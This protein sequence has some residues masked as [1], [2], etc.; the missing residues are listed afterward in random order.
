MAST[1]VTS[2]GSSYKATTE[3]PGN[4]SNNSSGSSNGI[5]HS[6]YSSS[7]SSSPS[8]VMST[9]TRI[10]QQQQQQQ[11]QQQDHQYQL[12]GG[13]DG[14]IETDDN[15][16]GKYRRQKRM[17]STLTYLVFAV[18]LLGFTIW[19]VG[20]RS[21]T[22]TNS[23][24]GIGDDSKMNHDLH[25]QR[26]RD[27]DARRRK[28]QKWKTEKEEERDD[29]V[30]SH[31]VVNKRW[32]NKLK[33]QEFPRGGSD[34]DDHESSSEE[35]DNNSKEGKVNAVYSWF[36]RGGG[37]GEEEEAEKLRVDALEEDLTELDKRMNSN[38]DQHIKWIDM[39]DVPPLH[40]NS[41]EGRKRR[42]LV[43]G[44]EGK[45][46]RGIHPGHNKQGSFKKF[47]QIHRPNKEK[48]VWE[49]E[50]DTIVNKDPT[51]RSTYVDYTK[52]QYRYPKKL[53][54]P[55]DRLGEY[56]KLRTYGELYKTWPQDA[57][58]DPPDIIQEDLIHFDYND[59][60]DMKA[61][62]KFRT[63][64]L[65]FKLINVPEL[66]AAN[67]KWTDEYISQQ[68]DTKKANGRANETPNNFFAF[69]NEPIWDVTKQGVPP[70]RNNDWTYKKWSKHARYADRVGLDANLPHFY[71]QSGVPAEERRQPDDTWSF[72]SKDLPSWSSSESNF[73][74]FQVE[75]QKG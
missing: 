52:H 56:P 69:F 41:K 28:N 38:K 12:R 39:S 53:F 37:E 47:F 46:V 23:E 1:I 4:Y 64:R 9:M 11:Q 16:Y 59:P 3:P 57:I 31:R 50:F 48:M 61:A 36:Q 18:S 7:S 34:N 75:S 49:E 40:P 10:H 20:S 44:R 21:N 2:R 51:A 13:K 62:L 65:P 73:I 19:Y 55:P 58:D 66:I 63:D 54:D 72:V 25:A 17:K 60:N 5:A 29:R 70:S 26:K 32:R 67:N 33:H 42:D 68:F 24:N 6:S 71:W 27:Q 14:G 35:D 74:V 15:K 30:D 22:T 8:T 43:G 45:G